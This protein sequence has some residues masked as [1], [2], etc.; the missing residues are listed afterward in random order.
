MELPVQMY[1]RAPFAADISRL[2]GSSFG[3]PPNRKRAEVY[4]LAPSTVLSYDR[5][6]A[7][8]ACI[9]TCC[10]TIAPPY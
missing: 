3:S 7:V 1:A 4:R 2:F 6:P 5:V 10:R 9:H 8:K